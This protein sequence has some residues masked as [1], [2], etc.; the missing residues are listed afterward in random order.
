MNPSLR[1]NSLFLL[2]FL[3]GFT[4]LIYESLWSHYLKLFLGHAAY[5]QTLVL[6][7]FMGGMSIGAAVA[8]HLSRSIDNLL[9][10]YAVTEIGIGLMALAFHPVFSA[11]TD[12]F[13]MRLLPGLDTPLMID[14]GKW[15]LAALLLL[16]PSL[17]LGATFPMMSGA[18]LRRFPGQDGSHLA[19]LYFSNSLGAA[20]GVLAASFLLIGWMGLPGTLYLSGIVNLLIGAAV[21]WLARNPE[22][23]PASAADA[24]S[25]KTLPLLFLAA[26]FVTGMASFIYEIAWIRM[27]SLVLGSTFHA[28]ELMLSA[29]IT[30]LALGSLTIRRYIDRIASPLA[31][32]AVIQLAMG[33]LA[34]LTLP[35]YTQSFDWMGMLVRT[36]PRDDGGYLLFNLAS[37]G[38]AFAI[39]LPA[40]FM[41][42][43]TLPLFTHVLIRNGYG[44]K[45]IG[46]IY[47]TN[48]LGAIAGILFAVHLALPAAGLKLTLASGA[49]LDLV[50]GVV[51]LR[52]AGV[53]PRLRLAAFA[54]LLI[55]IL[56]VRL[57]PMEGNTLGSGVYRTGQPQLRNSTTVFYRDGK[58][59]SISVTLSG[60]SRVMLST[61]GKPDAAIELDPQLPAARDE[62][63]MVMAAAVPLAMRP[64]AR[65]VANIGFGSGLT[66]H[67]V[68]AHPGV[69]ALYSIEIE[70][71]VIEGARAFLPRVERAYADPR[72]HMHIEDAKSWFARHRQ[73]F[74]IIISE[75]SNPW[76]SGVA[77]LFSDEF[78]AR[79]VGYLDDRG[80]LVQWL[81]LYEFDVD[82][83]ASVI[84]ALNRHFDDYAVY[85][86]D[87]SNILIVAA[88]HGTVPPLDAGIFGIPAMAA[89]LERVGI[90]STQDFAL[91]RLGTA[92]LLGAMTGVLGAP[93]NSDYYPYVEINAP[94]VR[95]MKGEAVEF[96][97]LGIY[98]LPLIEM[99]DKDASAW[100]PEQLTPVSSWRYD[101]VREAMA[102]RSALSGASAEQPG[103]PAPT[104]ARIEQWRARLQGC[105]SGRDDEAAEAL[106]E[107]A[108]STLA[109]LDR[110][111][112]RAMWHTPVWLP[113]QDRLGGRLKL[114][115]AVADRQAP[116]MLAAAEA[117]LGRIDDSPT[118]R[119]YALDAGLLAANSLG[120][121]GAVRRLWEQY[122]WSLYPD[123]RLSP[124][125]V[126]LLN[127]LRTKS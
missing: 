94:R 61:N 105:A 67:T 7:I 43:M 102:I 90:R 99:L 1:R 71:A 81:N 45:S 58:T 70:P 95:F 118:W 121:A 104:A 88:K 69:E 80:L 25:G 24:G 87:D 4:G 34:V 93:A 107:I 62:I 18:V 39:M 75:P 108:R 50:L 97:A 32:A 15:G 106:H 35:L 117:A 44:E 5:A 14:A 64:D 22:T 113:C 74:D 84:K 123:G 78:Y 2:F 23:R 19:T 8:G 60:S 79:I 40:T 10:A 26:A 37:H 54:A 49:M 92:Q 91:R 122:G 72:S 48:T 3:S 28:F 65:Q 82:L 86:T 13:L 119:R 12:F 68:L 85:L 101:K 109:Y 114:Y 38:I 124:E 51:L 77:S 56:V 76:V 6:V 126:L 96:P 98:P 73:R 16:P 116:A 30:G 59:A 111:G 83:A 115:R 42:G 120:D 110:Q 57:V 46:R 41:A 127:Y 31:V 52:V 21:L 17:L 11:S 103:L 36:L 47:A 112:L 63:T 33:V 53:A 66:S 20:L 100:L 29:F 89:E 125:L 9:K 55:P 27:L